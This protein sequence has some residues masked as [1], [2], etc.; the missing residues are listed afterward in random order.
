VFVGAIVHKVYQGRCIPVT[1]TDINRKY[2]DDDHA[3]VN[4]L[5]EITHRQIQ[6]VSG[7]SAQRSE[8]DHFEGTWHGAENCSNKLNFVD[9][10]EK[11][12]TRKR[13]S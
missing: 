12:S 4:V 10:E 6:G 1:V 5:G 11:A 7:N 2:V 3:A 9:E 8:D 13:G